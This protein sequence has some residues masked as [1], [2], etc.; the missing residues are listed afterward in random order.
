MTE[1]IIGSLLTLLLFKN[2]VCDVQFSGSC[3]RVTAL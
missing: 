1:K 3:E 2:V